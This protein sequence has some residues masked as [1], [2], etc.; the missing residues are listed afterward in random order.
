MD[1][2]RATP[3]L[4]HPIALWGLIGTLAIL[5]QAVV[6]LSA[7]GVQPFVRADLTPVQ[8]ALLAATLVF[9]AYTEGWRGFH[10]KFSP[11]V[12][13]RAAHLPAAPLLVQVL[14]PLAAMGL[15][16][17]SRKRRIVSWT[18]L[19]MIVAVVVA[20]RALPYPWRHIVDAGVVVGLTVGMVSIVWHAARALGGQ[21]PDVPPDLPDGHASEIAVPSA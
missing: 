16:W 2:N 1:P 4:A 7:L 10:L 13:V 17:A 12:V 21:P 5:G 20:V 15:I 8:W 3:G 6:R 19:G 9:F 18:I 14:A 11:R